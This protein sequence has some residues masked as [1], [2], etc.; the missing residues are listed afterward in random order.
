[1]KQAT[2]RD[3]DRYKYQ[4]L[5]DYTVKT[6]IIGYKVLLEETAFISLEEDGTLF[7]KARYAWDGASS[8]PDFDSIMRGSLVHD[9]FYQLLRME[10]LPQA[11][12]DDADRL[13][14]CMCKQD[15]MNTFL[16]WTVYKALKHF[17]AKAAKAGTQEPVKRLKAPKKIGSKK[18][19]C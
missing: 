9:A 5:E 13:I 12:R 7:I 14:Q 3:L 18:I 1:M 6:G 19:T 15:G 2:Y 11:L 8:C 10:K 16:A 4:L 17:G